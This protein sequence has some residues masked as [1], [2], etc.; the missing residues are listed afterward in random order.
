[1]SVAGATTNISEVPLWDLLPSPSRIDKIDFMLRVRLAKS[2]EYLGGLP[3]FGTGQRDALFR[4]VERLKAAPVSPWVFCLYSKL[5]AE[6][7]RA[8]QCDA[9][10]FNAIVEAASLPAAQG[11]IPLRDSTIPDSWWDHFQLLL[12]TEEPYPFGPVAPSAEQFSRCEDEIAASLELMRSIDSVWYEEVKRLLRS[13][14]LGSPP[15]SE[16]ASYFDGATTFFFWS[17]TLLNANHSRS[18]IPWVDLLVHESSHVLLF[19]LSSDGGLT[20][21]SGQ[22]RY[23][24]PIRAEKRP[25]EGI[26]HACFVTT[27]V[28]LAMKRLLDT[29]S[30]HEDDR[31]LAIQ[32]RQHNEEAGRESLAVLVRHA[33]P[34]RLG[35]AILSE[36]QEYWGNQPAESP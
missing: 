21:N 25:I 2:F 11:V 34:T 12:D 18:P 28:H 17:A 1:M 24:S 20:R 32:H 31:R 23:D 9:E 6:L 14:I 27:R 5:V 36:L 29:G 26:F 16:P 10:S 4:L 19:G 13:I 15:N 7:S 35:K 33:E 8:A 30:L 3:T 22:E